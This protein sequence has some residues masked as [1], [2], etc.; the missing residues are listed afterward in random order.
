MDVLRGG[1]VENSGIILKKPFFKQPKA[2]YADIIKK[3]P[4]KEFKDHL[5]NTHAH[6]AIYYDSFDALPLYSDLLD[7]KNKRGITPRDLLKSL[8]QETETQ[9]SLCV[10]KTKE[11]CFASLETSEQKAHFNMQVLNHLKFS[12]LEDLN[13]VLKRCEKKLED[14]SIKRK[15]LWIDS[16]YGN[17]FLS[18]KFAPCY[19]KWID[20]LIGYG[21]FAKEDIPQYSLIGEYTGI[22]RKRNSKLD[23]FNDY[24][25]G[26][27]VAQ[28]ETPFVVDASQE[29]SYTRFINHSDEPNLHSTWLINKGLCHIILVSQSY[30]PKDTQITYDYGPYY[31]RKRPSPFEL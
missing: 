14:E 7:V 23:K 6:L 2:F 27:V 29:G 12:R 4:H 5:G 22:V 24:I 18:K 28:S 20:P 15:N 3:Y 8:G 11:Q 25:F 16:L 21:L 31:W 10:Y 13:W 1:L 17:A 19:V 26:Y 9:G 30:I